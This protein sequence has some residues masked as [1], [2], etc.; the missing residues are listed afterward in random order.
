MAIAWPTPRLAPVTS[1]TRPDSC[2]ALLH[3]TRR[4][5]TDVGPDLL[6]LSPDPVALQ[7]VGLPDGRRRRR[8]GT[9]EASARP[10]DA[11][12]WAREEDNTA[13]QKIDKRFRDDNTEPRMGSVLFGPYPPDPRFGP[14]RPPRRGRSARLR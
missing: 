4:L 11:P 10:G 9:A 12:P 7:P 8:P 6:A 5:V 13:G 3:S 14:G 1:A 2:M